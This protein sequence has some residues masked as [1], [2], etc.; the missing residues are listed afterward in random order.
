MGTR[1][2]IRFQVRY[3]GKTGHPVGV[4]GAC[5]HLR[6]RGVLSAAE[7]D[8]FSSVDQWFDRFLPEPPFYAQGN[9]ERAIT[10]FK[11]PIPQHFEDQLNR[12]LQIL[13][14]HCVPYDRVAVDD[15]GE[16]IY[17]DTF[18]VATVYRPTESAE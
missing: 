16:I 17:E 11:D 12:L 3:T 7:D 18:Q 14:R 4:F 2:F 10:Y 8:L 9:P 15:V 5:H 1:Q 6:R 13:D